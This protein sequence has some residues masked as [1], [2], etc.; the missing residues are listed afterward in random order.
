MHG[1]ETFLINEKIHI[2]KKE[3][4]KKYGGDLNIEELAAEEITPQDVLNSMNA[5][6]FLSEKRLVLVKNFL[7]EKKA[8]IQKELAEK[9]KDVPETTV[10]IFYEIGK[11]DKRLSL[12]KHLQKIATIREFQA[13]KGTML[14]QWIINEAAKRGSK[15]SIMTASYLSEHVGTN[16]WQLT[17]EV[18]KLTLYCGSNEIK[19]QEIDLLTR[20]SAEVSIFKLT[21]Q[22]G[23]KQ[24]KEALKTLHELLES[25]EELPYIF[26][27]IA[28]QFRLLIQVKDML[29]KGSQKPEIINRL[30]LHPFVATNLLNQARNYDADGLKRAHGKL[31]ELD[32]K[33]KTG[34]V[35][36]LAT[37]KNHYLLHVE[38]LIVESAN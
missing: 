20:S 12:Y 3:F 25:G 23:R 21:D 28:R 29:R 13:L 19:S 6:P 36:Y 8:D 27:M 16:L 38:K 7:S 5:V 1:E 22:V 35:S 31:L 24:T 2:W 4:E 33:L 10:L 32:T 26:A 9:L 11:P 15:M 17:H 37:A 14:H 18:E 34:K 30:K